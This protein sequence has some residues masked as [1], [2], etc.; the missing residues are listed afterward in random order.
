[1]V[2][3]RT[4]GTGINKSQ[5]AFYYAVWGDVPFKYNNTLP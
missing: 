2:K 5:T 1:M 3:I 4:S